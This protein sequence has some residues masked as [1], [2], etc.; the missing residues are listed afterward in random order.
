M[1]ADEIMRQGVIGLADIV[2]KPGLIN[3]DFAD[4]RTV[5]SGAGRALMGIGR[6]FGPTRAHDAAMAA[7]SSPLLDF[8]ISEAKGVVFTI[9]GNSDM[10]LQEVNE[11]AVTISDMVSEDANIIFGT[12]VDDSFGDEISVT[13]VATSLPGVE[14]QPELE[15]VPEYKVVPSPLHNGHNGHHLNGAHKNGAYK[16]R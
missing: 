11:V 13:L 14:K 5:M 2:I 15:V 9:T 8:P 3:V 7:V 4:V 16:A 6:G 10:S 12:S 1:M